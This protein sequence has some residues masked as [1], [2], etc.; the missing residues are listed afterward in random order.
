[1]KRTRHFPA[2]VLALA[3]VAAAQQEHSTGSRITPP[4]IRVVSPVGVARGTT[5]ELTIEG[6]N[7]A[8][9]SAI[10]FSD[11]AVKGKIV[12]IKELPDLPDIRL[13][14]NGT[15][16]TID[17][18]PLPPR[19]QVSVEVEVAPDADVGKVN[20]RLLTPLG[21]SPEG[22][23]LVEPYYGES[24][25]KEPNDSPET[26]IETFLPSILAGTISKPGD[27]DYYKIEVKA[28]EELVFENGAMEIGSALEPVVAILRADN[29][30]VQQYGL[31]STASAAFFSHKFAAGGTY[32]V[33]VSDYQQSG[34]GSNFYRYKVGKFPV[35]SRAYPL[36]LRRGESRE[37]SLYG[38]GIGTEKI[39]VKGVPSP[40]NESAVILRA[41]TENGKA[42]NRMELAL[43]DEPEVES[44]GKNTTLAAAQQLTLP[45]AING[46][47]A[48]NTA[49]Y[50]RFGAKK[51]QKVVLDVDARRLG[52]DLDSEIEVLDASGK[53]MER[54][55]VRAVWETN[56]T[57]RDHDSVQRGM[58]ILSWNSLAVGD[59]LL[60]GSEIVRIEA[61]PR[62]PDDDFIAESFGGQRISYFGT[63]GEAHAVDQAVYKVQ[64]HPP[65]TKFT[66][67]GLPLVH[68]YYHN[69]DGGPG[70]GK[71]SYL[72]F[73]A[74][75]DGEYVVKL[76]DVRN[77]GGES[78]AY[79]LTIAPP[80]PDFRLSMNPRNPN[81]PRGGVVPVTVT[82]FRTD[83][84]EGPIDVG[85]NSLPAGVHATKGVIGKEQIS[86]VVLL[87][88]DAEAKLADAA[89]FEITGRARIQGREVAHTASPEDKLKLV[90]LMPKPDV[91]M[92]SE[93]KEVTL[94]P[95]GKAEIEVSVARQRDYG[96]RVPVQ[97]LN[98]PPRVHVLN[99]GLNGVLV[100]EDETKRSF[101]VE[102]LSSAEP[103]DQMIYVAGTV[104]T[105][106]PQQSL[107]AAPQAIHLLVKPKATQAANGMGKQAS[108]GAATRR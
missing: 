95:G 30:V 19:N 107:Y 90:A 55:T 7:L 49:S 12:R 67:N 25:D 23:F 79:R 57:L 11:P 18:G 94:E 62:G 28:G 13:G 69:D 29:T 38:P 66:P 61:L 1:M 75:A 9:A 104:E 17:L 65:G 58:R 26:A 48:K 85:V 53:P 40:E 20:F 22:T 10:Y 43:G 16:S 21:T 37:F 39:T 50:F 91:L 97:V 45:A 54:A 80:R 63:S 87:S 59:Y 72:Q 34:R 73:T 15:P 68:L 106:S 51:G 98:L 33:R 99:V 4:T 70:W 86:T 47:I 35:V 6:L 82:A 14:S 108:L 103:V 93:T 81:V 46:R 88:A 44:T 31:D 3:T 41:K 89:R 76:K 52:S 84:F 101:T 56:L 78:Y 83:G 92:T 100:A 36:G 60:V 27:V 32:Y 5:A 64:I 96:G 42:F 74:P 71:D 2:L 24:A 77:E 105:R 102:A 8:Q